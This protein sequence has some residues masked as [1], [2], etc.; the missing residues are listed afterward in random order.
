MPNKFNLDGTPAHLAFITE[1]EFQAHIRKEHANCPF[2]DIKCRSER[3]LQ[4]HVETMHSGTTLEQ[5]KNVPCTHPGCDKRF[6]KNNNL[7]TH[8]RTAHMG[9]R[10]VCGTFDVST[11][12]DIS[13]FNLANGCHDEFTS[14]YALHDHIRTAH[15]GLPTV[16]NA[17]KKKARELKDFEIEEE[18]REEQEYVEDELMNDDEYILPAD[19]PKKNKKKRATG[20]K[21]KP[22]PNFIDDHIGLSYQNDPRRKIPCPVFNCAY[23]L[24]RDHDLEGHMRRCHKDWTLDQNP[25]PDFA[26]DPNIGFQYPA[27]PSGMT[28]F[29]TTPATNGAGDLMDTFEHAAGIDDELQHGAQH[30]GQFWMGADQ[31]LFATNDSQWNM[32]ADEMDRL[33][34]EA[35]VS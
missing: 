29:G 24:M 4:K 31:P 26:L 2:C 9:E 5:R 13:I 7:K 14:K 19:N 11:Q 17:Y 8:I 35:V 1:K 12:P 22:A 10:Y 6:T 30:V 15:L 20:F 25:L 34:G 27:T 18:D 32:E 3:E 21:A 28:S 16:I 33:I 23:K